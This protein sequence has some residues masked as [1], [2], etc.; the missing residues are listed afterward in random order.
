MK[1]EEIE[2]RKMSKEERER[3]KKAEARKRYFDE[4]GHIRSRDAF[5]KPLE[6]LYEEE[7]D[8][9]EYISDAQMLVCLGLADYLTLE[10][11]E[12]LCSVTEKPIPH[13]IGELVKL[14]EY[15][16]LKEKEI[17]KSGAGG[18]VPILHGSVLE[19]IS[20]GAKLCACMESGIIDLDSS[21][22]MLQRAER[23]LPGA[24]QAV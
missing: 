21:L 17:V 23:Y 2:I 4:E 7:I 15:C 24:K 9:S 10:F 16:L 22:Q 19:T 5:V 14:V 18:Q 1:M 12:D 13:D 11:F 8:L 3:L 6:M 20:F